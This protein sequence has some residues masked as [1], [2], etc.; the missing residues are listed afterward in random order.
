M[1]VEVITKPVVGE[2]LQAIS[3][4]YRAILDVGYASQQGLSF[5][6]FEALAQQQKLVTNNAS[7]KAY[8]FFNSQNI[9]CLDEAALAIPP[10]FFTTPYQ[11]LPEELI[12]PYRLPSWVSNLL[13]LMME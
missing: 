1:R 3:S 5:R 12:R 6:F 13:E 7:V 2:A 9:H 4:A 10:A 11:A 8:P